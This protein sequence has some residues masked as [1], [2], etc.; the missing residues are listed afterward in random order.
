M[1]EKEQASVLENYSG[2]TRV[3]F[4]LGDPI[5]Q[6]KAPG[7]LTREFEQRG[8]DAIVV[9]LH[10]SPADVDAG[11]AAIT[12][13]QNVDGLIATIPHKFA[14][15]ARC[16]T[17]SERSQFLGVANVARRNADGSWHGDMLD[18]EG[19][20][21]PLARAGCTFEG[22]GAL[23][24]GAGGAG[25]AIA[26]ALLDRGVARLAVHDVDAKRRD[27]LIA[28]LESRFAGRIVAGSADPGDAAIVVNATPLGMKPH[29]PLPVDVS[30]LAPAA[31]VGDVVTVPEMTPMLIAAHQRGCLIQTGV[32]MFGGNLGLMADF[33]AGA[34]G[35]DTSAQQP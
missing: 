16:A 14:L 8:R 4:I 20:A 28:K 35:C 9:P 13:A 18:G 6:V 10:Q 27:A 3:I 11:I 22:N 29:D 31:F 26:L 23:L 24:V 34:A 21:D 32:G 33:F 1:C 19:F 25:S 7:G 2:A 15:A 17:L 5:A 12:R 30:R